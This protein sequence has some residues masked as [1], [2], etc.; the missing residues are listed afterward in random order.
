MATRRTHLSEDRVLARARLR[1]T[2]SGRSYTARVRTLAVALAGVA[3]ISTACSTTTDPEELNTREPETAAVSPDPTATPDGRVGDA[4]FGGAATVDALAIEPATRTVAVLTDGGTSLLLTDSG[5]DPASDPRR[6]RLATPGTSLHAGRDGEILVTTTEG[7]VRVD[8]ESGDTTT[9]AVPDGAASAIVFGDGYAVGT[10]RGSVVVV[11]ADGSITSTIAGQASVDALVPAGEDL[12]ALDT[13]QTAVTAVNVAGERLGAALRAGDGA[14]RM[15]GCGDGAI[16]VAD[17]TDD[18][19]LIFTGDDLIMRQ[20]APV[21][22]APFAVACSDDG[23]V[24][25]TL[26]ETNQVVGFDISS[27]MPV[28]SDRFS[29]VRQPNSVAVDSQS[30]ELFVGSGSGAGVQVIR[31]RE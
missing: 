7:V 27:G 1:S 26:T 25:V 29:T 13:R 11:D 21:T 19:L 12:I 16:A 15:T 2:H 23:T 10:P 9:V 31:T 24:W 17:T 6:V 18:E 3:A 20:R 14:T 4:R 8:V 22:G 30:G 5:S 28:E